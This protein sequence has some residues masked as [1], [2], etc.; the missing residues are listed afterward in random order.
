MTRIS[1]G[2]IGALVIHSELLLLLLAI[3]MLRVQQV[4]EVPCRS[5]ALHLIRRLKRRGG[6]GIHVLANRAEPIGDV[7]GK[8]GSYQSRFALIFLAEIKR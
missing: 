2:L 8:N 4:R 7:H 1:P 6:V 5:C 3:L